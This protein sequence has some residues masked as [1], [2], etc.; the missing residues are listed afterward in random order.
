MF[1]AADDYGMQV[2]YALVIDTD[3]YAGN[4]EREMCC[5]ITGYEGENFPGGIEYLLKTAREQL[6][7]KANELP[8][9][10]DT[11]VHDEYGPIVVTM[12][13]S[14]YYHSV[15]IMLHS[16][17]PADVLALMVERAKTFPAAQRENNHQ[18][19]SQYPW[20]DPTKFKE[21]KILAVRLES[22]KTVVQKTEEVL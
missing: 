4:F 8:D 16:R 15:A 3:S 6:G 20:Y 19:H 14:P 17:P 7:E 1:D 10:F 22:Y 21:I 9:Y 12:T 13:G 18:W 2:P 5:W 11:V